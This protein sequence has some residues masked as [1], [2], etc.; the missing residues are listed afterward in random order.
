M[1]YNNAPFEFTIAVVGG[2]LVGSLAALST[3]KILSN[4]PHFSVKIDVFEQHPSPGAAG[5]LAQYDARNLVISSA[6]ADYFRSLKIWDN[7]QQ[8]L[9]SIDELNISRMNGPGRSHIAAID[10]GVVALGYVAD[11]QELA[12]TLAELAKTEGVQFHYNCQLEKIKPVQS[13][14]QLQWPGGQGFFNLVIAADGENSWVCQSLGFFKQS[15]RYAQKALVANV[16]MEQAMPGVAYER[17]TSSGAVTLLPLTQHGFERRMSLVWIDSPE[18]LDELQSLSEQSFLQQLAHALPLKTAFANK[19]HS[20]VYPLRYQVRDERVRPHLV[21]VG[22]A[23]QTLHPIAAQ[24]F[25][26]AVRDIR[27][28][29]DVCF[30]HLQTCKNQQTAF[31]GSFMSEFAK[32]RNQDVKRV[33][34][35]VDVLDRAF[36]Q[37]SFP[38]TRGLLQDLALFG[39]EIAPGTKSL[40]SQFAMGGRRRFARAKSS[41]EVPGL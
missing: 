27:D 5:Y 14:Y 13:G 35:F 36:F 40:L 20:K 31:S 29:L 15:Q 24:G 33:R 38:F 12:Q 22:N 41:L 26:L 25:N 34:T 21:L 2:G 23:A 32:I 17:F 3:A 11:M 9:V 19:G 37:S 4:S 30:E 18:R 39:F 28:F 7:L 1:N 8:G 16:N 10:E 6:T